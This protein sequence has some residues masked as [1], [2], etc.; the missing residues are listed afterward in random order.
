M[1]YMKGKERFDAICRVAQKRASRGAP[2][3][4]IAAYLRSMKRDYS[5]MV[6]PILEEFAKE[7]ESDPEHATP[8]TYRGRVS[9]AIQQRGRRLLESLHGMVVGEMR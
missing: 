3:E 1:K 2:P 6:N 5:P 9:T 4:A 7:V 8:P